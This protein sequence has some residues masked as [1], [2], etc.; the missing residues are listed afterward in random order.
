MAD[1]STAE[2]RNRLAKGETKIRIVLGA[3]LISATL[4]GVIELGSALYWAEEGAPPAA[5]HDTIKN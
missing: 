1:A 4:L 3:I 2:S 5:V